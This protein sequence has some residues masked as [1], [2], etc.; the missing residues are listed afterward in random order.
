[1][2][3]GLIVLIAVVAAIVLITLLLLPRIRETAR[4]KARERELSKRRNQAV[5]EH[6]TVADTRARD[7]EQAEQR[8]RIARQEAE[9]HQQ[10]ASAHERGLADDQLIKDGE[11]ERFAGTSAVSRDEVRRDG[12]RDGD[13]VPDRDDRERASR[14]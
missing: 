12:D 8:A 4:V 6:R 2:S 7:A 9:L 13:G 5:D 10:Q 1:V 3:T 11:R 14:N